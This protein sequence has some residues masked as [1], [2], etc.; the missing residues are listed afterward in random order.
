MKTT[1]LTVHVQAPPERVFAVFSDLEDLPQRIPAIVRLE[2]LTPGP[3]GV[4]TRFRETRRMFGKEHAEEMEFLAFEPGKSY[5]IGAQSCGCE[6]RSLFTFEAEGNGTRVR[7]EFGARP[8]TFGAK[9]MGFLMG[10]MMA[11]SMKKAMLQDMESLKRVLEDGKATSA[12]A[13]A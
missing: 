8:L 13:G 1:T 12:P 9:V 2:K 10:W 7:Q 5:T 3:V 4:G 11:G 6:Y